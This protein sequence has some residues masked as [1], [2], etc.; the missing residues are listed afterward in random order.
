MFMVFGV[1][2]ETLCPWLHGPTLLADILFHWDSY[3]KNGYLGKMRHFNLLSAIDWKIQSLSCHMII[4]F[5]FAEE[6]YPSLFFPEDCR[7]RG[8]SLY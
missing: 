8:L 4:T 5:K 1:F 6:I 7:I 2:W 3:Q